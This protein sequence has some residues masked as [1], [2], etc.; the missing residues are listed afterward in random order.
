MTRQREDDLSREIRAHL[1]LEAE[2][3][4]AEGVPEAEARR[5]AHRAFGNVTRAREESRAAWTSRWIDETVRD[6]RYVVR[7]LA[8]HPG[9]AAVSV[10]TLAMGVGANIAIFSLTDQVLLRSL[11]VM[12]PRDLVLLE[13]PGP[14]QGYTAADQAG[15]ARVFSVPMFRGLQQASPDVCD[16]LFARFS[17]P[18]T[19]SGGDAA[20]RITAEVVS[21]EYFAALGVQPSLGRTL[22]AGDDRVPDAHPVTVL[23]HAYWTRRFGRDPAAVG[24]SLTLNGVPMTIVGVVRSDF[25]GLD[26]GEPADVFVP[27]TMKRAVTPTRDDLASWRSR[28]VT[29]GGRL[30]SGVSIEGA[31]VALN[32]AY[33]QLLTEDIKT[34]RLGPGAERGMFLSKSLVVREGRQGLSSLRDEFSL[35]LLVLMGMVGLVLLIACAN[36]ANLFLARAAGQQ[37]EVAIRL[38]LGAGRRRVVRQRFAEAV[39]L[40]AGGAVVGLFV[41]SLTTRGVIG[42]L[43]FEGAR[44]LS[45]LPDS[46]I[47]AFGLAIAALSALIVG[48]WPALHA[49][50]PALMSIL[51]EETASAPGGSRHARARQAAII[52]QV[53]LSAVLLVGAGTFVRSLSA[54][55]DMA[56]GFAPADLLQFRVD[57]GAGRYPID[58]VRTTVARLEEQLGR[59]P[60][61]TTVASATTAVM[62]G[63]VSRQTLR[64]PG[65]QPGE[66]ENMNARVITVG[67]RYFATMGVALIRGREFDA[68]D[69]SAARKVAVINE[70]MAH[71]FWADQDPIGRRFGPASSTTGEDFEIVGVVRNSK[72]ISVRDGNVRGYYVPHTQAARL[73]DVTVYLRHRPG[74][75]GVAATARRVVQDVDPTLPIYNVRSVASQLEE[76]LTSERLLAALAL[77]FGGLAT[78]LA[79]IGL[80]G[81]MAFSVTRRIREIGI[82]IAL[83]A[84]PRSVLSM[85][86]REAAQLVGVGV[87]IG[88][89]LV[90]ALSRLLESQLFGVS[91]TDPLTLTFAAALLGLVGLIASYLPARRA[92]RVDP[93][94]A[95]RYE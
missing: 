50:S 35:V 11:P 71:D 29:I 83:G 51:K 19:A 16:G 53:G 72:V 32:M 45:P 86:L 28:W 61:V 49:T 48:L 36:V 34:A 90:F 67:P 75:D 54:L 25:A 23:S 80:Y 88:L 1:Q 78:G 81:V 94:V 22:D 9:F 84:T 46:R 3:R 44:T 4:M 41:A 18:V 21:G 2:D 92:T 55:R 79:A 26:R 57:L 64:V 62:S 7:S 38:A 77:L 8:R 76:S 5:Q 37:R 95:L 15:S 68:T 87:I 89:P 85:V 63:S 58:H 43:P 52:I 12:N 60:G 24:A 40:A 6:L 39:V 59:I 82:R 66:R 42:L 70:A 47:V 56:V 91:A 14:Y 13:G 10:L 20:E 74:A 31:A 69:T 93:L 73:T 33:R 27:L 65:Y 17:A 30:K